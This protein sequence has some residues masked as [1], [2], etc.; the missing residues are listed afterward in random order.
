[1][2]YHDRI[3]KIISLAVCASIALCGCE[4]SDSGESSQNTVQ[5]SEAVSDMAEAGSEAVSSV[6]ETAGTVNTSVSGTTVSE[7]V[8]G[9]SAVSGTA[10]TAETSKAAQTA[11]VPETEKP[12]APATPPPEG[13]K[14]NT[15]I[16]PS[17]YG[18][19]DDELCDL[20]LRYYGSRT[21]HRPD[22][23]VT[24][25][26]ENGVVSV[27]LYD[28]H[29]ENRST[30]DWYYVDRM[31]GKGTDVIGNEIDISAPAADIWNPSVPQREQIKDD[32]WCAIVYIGLLMSESIQEFI[33]H[34]VAYREFTLQSEG[35]E[36]LI[37]LPQQNHVMAHDA[38]ELYLII[39]RDDEAQVTV[40]LSD[41][42]EN[43]YRS[44]RGAPFLLACNHNKG[45]TDVKI[46][47]TDNSGEHPAFSPEIHENST[48]KVLSDLDGATAL[49]EYP[50][51]F[52]HMSDE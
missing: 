17:E 27:H 43:I 9:T 30:C 33:N 7:I 10:K 50:V 2:H 14:P 22:N 42:S 34:N 51:V 16:D 35:Y 19:S 52:Y 29:G 4:T 1:M 24:E 13:N 44:Y 25:G 18:Y 15:V 49:M 28:E 23:I 32:D 5:V 47:I 12:A 40:S 11:R 38:R 48:G 41:G 45:E 39:P 26:E 37:D 46:S 31:T 8:S 36:W 3:F 21:N 6:S 20:A